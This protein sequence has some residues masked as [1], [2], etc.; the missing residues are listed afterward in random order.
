MGF[1]D[2]KSDGRCHEQNLNSTIIATCH[3]E[4][5]IELT[6][7]SRSFVES[8]FPGREKRSVR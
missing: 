8:H 6:K 2:W 3:V 7:Y 4:H 1:V 5:L